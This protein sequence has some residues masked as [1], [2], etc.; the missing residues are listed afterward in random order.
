M[1]S[2]YMNLLLTFSDGLCVFLELRSSNRVL[3]CLRGIFA[4][5]SS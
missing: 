5:P 3:D 4:Q 2:L 1:Y